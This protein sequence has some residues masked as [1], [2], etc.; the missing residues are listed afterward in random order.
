MNESIEW[1]QAGDKL[2][3]NRE[4][5]FYLPDTH[6]VRGRE[7]AGQH[8]A[9]GYKRAASLVL[10][11]L[12]ETCS[13]LLVFPFISL[14][15][16]HI[17]LSLKNLILIVSQV[18]GEPKF[19]DGHNLPALW[20]VLN[21]LTAKDQKDN[22]ELRSAF[23][24]SKEIIKELEKLDPESQGARYAQPRYQTKSDDADPVYL[25]DHL[26]ILPRHFD[27]N[28]FSQILSKVICLIDCLRM[29]YLTRLAYV[30]DSV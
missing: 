30:A 24:A 27:F 9:E 28:H 6:S 22:S 12:Q 15:R 7:D 29:E 23:L 2:L 1:P 8:Y 3:I 18:H 20:N 19:M 26:R 4:P 25:T 11:E 17:E 16:H 21:R 14:W 5:P 13:E 10:H